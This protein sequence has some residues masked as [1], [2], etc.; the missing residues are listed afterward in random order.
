MDRTGHQTFCEARSSSAMLH[1]VRYIDIGG[2]E[3]CA[4]WSRL[5]EA[6]GDSHSSASKSNLAH[7]GNMTVDLHVTN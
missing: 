6:G 1:R 4:R 5:K 3:P 7:L 2:R